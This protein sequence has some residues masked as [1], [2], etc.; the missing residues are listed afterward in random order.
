MSVE[1]NSFNNLIDIKK[2]LDDNSIFFWIECGLLLGLYRDG[3]MIKNDED[4]IDIFLWLDDMN[5]FLSI[6]KDLKDAGFVNAGRQR[7]RSGGIRSISLKR[8]GAHIDIFFASKIDNTVFYSICAKST[9]GI[10]EFM[11]FQ[12]PDDLYSTFGKVSW[13]GVEF[14]C[15]NNIDGYLSIRYGSDWKTPIL[16]KNGWMGPLN[17]ELNPCLKKISEKDMGNLL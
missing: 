1:D 16:R 6:M 13:R 14:S 4:D 12:F 15:P 5:R 8:N 9:N 2:I 17:D 7:R 3:G 11:T 10:D